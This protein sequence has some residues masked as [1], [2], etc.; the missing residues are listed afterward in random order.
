MAAVILCVR[1][2]P[3][4][5]SQLH[6]PPPRIDFWNIQGFFFLLVF[7]SSLP[8]LFFFFL[9][10]FLKPLMHVSC[11][12]LEYVCCKLWVHYVPTWRWMSWIWRVLG[13]ITEGWAVLFVLLSSQGSKETL[14][15]PHPPT[16]PI[17]KLFHWEISQ[18]PTHVSKKIPPIHIL[19]PWLH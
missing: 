9:S 15:S 5:P 14:T 2:Q 16:L 13:R 10:L 7:L 18:A 1:R 4:G 8:L 19:T 3:P 11:V 6:P 12:N 17:S